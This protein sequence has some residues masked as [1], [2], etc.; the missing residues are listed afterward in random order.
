VNKSEDLSY[1]FSG[2]HVAK[3]TV[4]NL[5]GYGIPLVFAVI[6]IPPLINE[7]GEEKFG[8]LS[9]IWMVIGYFSFFDF[10][11]ASSLTKIVSE[12]IGA[13][14]NEDIP[15]IFWLSL[16]LMLGLTVYLRFQ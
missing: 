1:L 13:N 12:K 9:L 7:L 8:I 15:G 10:G 2:R 3:N 6:L 11:I 16:V 14:K 5:L 4:Y